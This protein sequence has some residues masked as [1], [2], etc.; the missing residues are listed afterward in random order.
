MYSVT[1][2]AVDDDEDGDGWRPRPVWIPDGD[3]FVKAVAAALMG[4]T[5]VRKIHQ[6]P[7]DMTDVGAT[8]LIEALR[9]C[10]VEEFGCVQCGLMN[11]VTGV[12]RAKLVEIEALFAHNKAANLQD[13]QLEAQLRDVCLFC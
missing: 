6:P 11:I 13:A 12:S 4:N 8:A 3:A 9:V 10:R 2:H 1:G 5:H 7:R